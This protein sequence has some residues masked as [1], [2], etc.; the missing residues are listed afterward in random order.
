MVS[1]GDQS[2][3]TVCLDHVCPCGLLFH[4]HT[5]SPECWEILQVLSLKKSILVCPAFGA[6]K[7]DLFSNQLETER[8]VTDFPVNV[9]LLPEDQRA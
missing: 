1:I 7:G 4:T 9:R 2:V 3:C 5:S 6:L 8:G